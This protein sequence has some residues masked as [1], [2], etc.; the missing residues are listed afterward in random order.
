MVD[1]R[2]NNQAYQAFVDNLHSAGIKTTSINAEKEA[3]FGDYGSALSDDLKNEII[4]SFDCDQDYE[5]QNKI[6]GLYQDKSVINSGNFVQAC[7]SMGLAVKV[8]YE[9]TSYISDYKAGNFNNNMINGAIAKY[10]I[11]DGMGGEI[12]IADANGNGALES[13]EIFMNQILTGI[14]S[15]IGALTTDFSAQQIASGA[16]SGDASLDFSNNDYMAKP[17]QSTLSNRE[18]SEHI[19]QNNF[20]EKV[21]EF[22]DKGYT[23]SIAIQRAKELLGVNMDYT[24]KTEATTTEA[25]IFV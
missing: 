10:T 20:N 15:E 5:L 25:P 12:V 4:N 24:G 6:A 18:G 9:K 22:I 16:S 7:K 8:E 3:D 2:A 17:E 1:V 14:N 21:E 13:E 23:K 11:S 19:S